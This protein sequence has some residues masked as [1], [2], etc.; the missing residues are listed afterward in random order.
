MH[1]RWDQ[2]A[3]ILV[4]WLQVLAAACAPVSS[5]I[6][7]SFFSSSY[8]PNWPTKVFAIC[9]NFNAFSRKGNRDRSGRIHHPL[10]SLTCHLNL[11][12]QD[13]AGAST[14]SLS[15]RSRRR[16]CKSEEADERN[17]HDELCWVYLGVV[18]QMM[19]LGEVSRESDG[20]LMWVSWW[21]Y[22]LLG[23]KQM[24]IS[25]LWF[26]KGPKVAKYGTRTGYP[27][28]FYLVNL[29]RWEMAGGTGPPLGKWADGG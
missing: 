2:S 1:H 4:W 11:T 6:N 20:L 19:I 26:P 14:G 25:D 5:L 9:S 7:H 13:V 18:D 29:S 24:K 28:G 10:N 17:F 12:C 27:Y 8:D 22:F 3:Q 15:L 23:G 21:A 16:R